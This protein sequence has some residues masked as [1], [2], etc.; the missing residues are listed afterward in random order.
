MKTS[1]VVVTQHVEVT[2]DESK[3]TSKFTS[4]FGEYYFKLDSIGAHIRHLGQGY[5]RGLWDN[6]SFIE[7]YGSAK[8]FGISFS[9]VDVDT[10]TETEEVGTES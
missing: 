6:D 1:L 7:G 8:E 2:V 3:F 9:L 4:E 5:A 10:E